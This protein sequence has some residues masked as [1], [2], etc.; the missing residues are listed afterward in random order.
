MIAIVCLDDKNG[1]VFNKRR[2]SRDCCVVE[3]ILDMT[4]GGCLW[5]HPFSE[6]LFVEREAEQIHVRQEFLKCA[7]DGEYCFVE[8]H[9]LRTVEEKI[10]KLIVFRWNRV[11]PADLR[12]DIAL[13]DWK[14][15]E[16][17]EFVGNS[18]EKIT[19][20]VYVR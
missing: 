9:G 8:N 6:P 15:T 18:H 5:I 11:Y 1:M 4:E 2:Q 7:G 3:R 19:R 14:K 16:E 17:E 13:E 12:L 10:E 20:E